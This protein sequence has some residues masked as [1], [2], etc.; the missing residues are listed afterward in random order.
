MRS[1]LLI[2]SAVLCS[3]PIG[4]TLPQLKK[5]LNRQAGAIADIH[6]QQVLDNLALFAS[7]RGATPSFALPSGGG[8]TVNNTKNGNGGLNWNARTLTGSSLGGSATNSLVQNFTLQPIN[9]P[10]RLEL[11]KCVYLYATCK[12][13][14]ECLGCVPKLQNFFGDRFAMG[15]IPQ[16]FFSTPETKPKRRDCLYKS[17]SYCGCHVVVE[18]CRFNDLS[19][20]TMAI[21]DIA[22]VSDEEWAR[23]IAGPAEDKIALRESFIANVG[24]KHRLI[25]AEYEV[26]ASIFKD[27]QKAAVG[28]PGATKGTADGVARESTEPNN[29][30][31][32]IE[33]FQ[34]AITPSRS[35]F[36]QIP[37][38]RRVDSAPR[39]ES[40]LQQNQAGILIQ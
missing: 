27:L 20:L 40:L 7:N 39:I 23:R 22:T 5:N 34:Q 14:D 8:T 37:Q 31:M 21:L 24:G 19:R 38:R 36:G 3:L 26:S 1:L 33:S 9:D 25:Q 11:M 32:D 30:G 2:L 15:C 10:D 6:E 17:G 13:A 29:P 18:P 16:C 35:P 12:N 28:P 4:C